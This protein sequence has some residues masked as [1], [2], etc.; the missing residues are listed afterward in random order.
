MEENKNDSNHQRLI[1]YKDITTIKSQMEKNICKLKIDNKQYTGFFCKIPF[2]NEVNEMP[3]L[4]TSYC[5]SFK[6]IEEIKVDIKGEIG[7]K[8]IKIKDRIKFINKLYKITII[9]LKKEDNV[10]SYLELDKNIVNSINNK[11][12]N[13]RYINEK[14]Y[15]IQYHDEELLFN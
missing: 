3:V 15:L 7:Q 1:S 10:N 5:Q 6:N 13:E 4:I 8:I 2:T 9:E 14:A 11:I 12:E